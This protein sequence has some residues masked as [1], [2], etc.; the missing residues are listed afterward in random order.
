MITEIA[1]VEIVA[2]RESEFESALATAVESVLSKAHGYL[3]FQL[4]RGIERPSVYTFLINWETLEDHTVGFRQSDLFVKW[5]ESIGSFFL[6]PPQIEH[7]T[8]IFSA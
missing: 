8:P 2:G 7:W 6:T 1:V 4:T 5:R 3:G